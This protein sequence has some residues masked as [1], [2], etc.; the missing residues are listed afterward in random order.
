M[1]IAFV[2][3]L[4]CYIG[5]LLAQ[6]FDVRIANIFTAIYAVMFSGVQA[7][8]NLEFIGGISGSILRTAQYF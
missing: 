2:I 1:L 5:A 7:G 3:C 6:N 8:T 4:I